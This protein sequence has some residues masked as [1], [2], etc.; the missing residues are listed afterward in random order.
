MTGIRTER[1]EPVTPGPPVRVLRALRL[2]PLLAWLSSGSAL[3]SESPTVT[4]AAAANLKPAIE[5]IASLFR[6]RHPGVEVTVILGASGTFFAQIANGAPFDLFL[7]AD[8]TYPAKVVEQGLADGKAFTF[9][10]GRLAVWVPAGSRLDL[11]GRG[12][13]ALADPSAGKVAMPNPAVAP[14]GRAAREALEKAG[15]YEKVK[16]R[17]VLGQNVGQAA[18]FAQTGNV[19]AAF[20]P[21]SLI[22]VPPLSREGRSWLVPADGHAP[23]EQAGVVLKGA[24]QPAL[25]RELAA[26]LASDEA[27]QVLTRLGY[28]VPAR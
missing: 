23:I 13:L 26:F 15:I 20:L 28:G 18:Q 16:D 5:Q 6:A 27:R 19:A 2:L 21:R 9:A 10:V 8:S 22:V 17:I 25:A 1:L 3:A 24:R 11:D 4:V 14:Y 12:L 7:S